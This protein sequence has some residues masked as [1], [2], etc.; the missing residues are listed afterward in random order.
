MQKRVIVVVSRAADPRRVRVVV[1]WL[2]VLLPTAALV[3]SAGAASLN[4]VAEEVI[5]LDVDGLPSGPLSLA[6]ALARA[7]QVAGTPGPE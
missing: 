1:R 6:D 7:G 3:L 5:T 2:R 4:T